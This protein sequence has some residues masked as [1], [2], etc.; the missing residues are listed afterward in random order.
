MTTIELE[1]VI[2]EDL[3]D[4]ERHHDDDRVAHLYRPGAVAWVTA[5]GAPYNEEWHRGRHGP[6]PWQ[7]GLFSCPECGVPL[8]MDCILTV[9]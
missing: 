4:E 6:L 1:P 5:C 9:S 3:G 2:D 8:C 7:P